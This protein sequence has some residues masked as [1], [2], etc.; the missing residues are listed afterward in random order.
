MRKISLPS[1]Y[2]SSGAENYL[3]IQMAVRGKLILTLSRVVISWSD[4]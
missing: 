1:S 3:E 4:K 2:A